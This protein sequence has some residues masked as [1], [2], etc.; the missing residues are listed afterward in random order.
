MTIPRPPLAEELQ[1]FAS[2]LW[3]SWN[4]AG[5][6]VFRQLDY[7]LWCQTDH[8]PIKI[9]KALPPERFEEAARDAGFRGCFERAVEQLNRARSGTATWWRERFPSSSGISI[10]YFSAEFGVHQ[11]V[12]LYA[13]GLGVLA[14][15]HCKE[16]SD[17]GVPL[18]GIGFRYSM[19]YFHQIITPEGNQI[20]IYDRFS[21]SDT[22]LERALRPD[23]TPC[24]V[25]I[26][27]AGGPLSI[28]VWLVRLGRV[29]VYLLDT[30]IEHNA[31]WARDLTAR[32]YVGELES[33][34]QQEVVLGLGGVRALRA[35]GYHPA[36]W[37]LNEGHAAFVILER[38][39][40]L[41]EAGHSLEQATETVRS[42]TVFTTHT[43]VP[44]GH[45]SFPIE[46]IEDQFVDFENLDAESRQALFSLG[47]HDNG[48]GHRFNMTVLA[49]R[50]SASC[51]AVSQAH[52]DVTRSMFAT[53]LNGRDDAV[54]GITNGVH[55]G[56]W[57]APAIDA[58]FQRYLGVNW[59]EHQDDPLFWEDVSTIPDEELWQ[60]RQ[61]LK[62]YLLEII[63]EHA[64][65]RWTAQKAGA[66]QLAASGTLLDPNALTIGFSRRFT[67]YKR[68][69]LIFHDEERLARL[70]SARRNPVQLIF[71]GKAHPADEAGKR[72]LQRIY[73]RAADRRF[74]G[75]IA[76]IDEY[77]L[78]IA[79]FLV[80]GCDV[81]L[82]NPR[83]PLEACGTSG[84]KASINGVPHLSVADGWWSE[85]YNG[86]NGWLI[87][88]DESADDA[89][90]AE[91]I[92]RLLEEHIVP[93]FYERD[94]R[95]VPLR[96]MSIVKQ[97]IRTVAPRF[98]ARRMVKQYVED[99]YV[100]R[101][102]GVRSASAGSY[103]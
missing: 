76:F 14:G 52:R 86:A 21:I 51:N 1:Q 77:N 80:Q 43:P 39:R 13:G 66:S 61:S 50:G 74:A 64:R 40:E 88:S 59:R 62:A 68:P 63:R 12:P 11:S 95:G 78:H 90:E 55:I 5:R 71:A 72:S 81:W 41:L 100:P 7:A 73:T 46:W 47:D 42:T 85:G 84:M 37:H 34:L 99:M 24:T 98:C 17:L 83:K 3:W 82:N 69:E 70:L 97:A 32:L 56:T 44:A 60:V 6:E 31:G 102:P 19:G 33:R 29:K 22:P 94:G 92:Y 4:P 96:W 28:D 48:S 53:I 38:I 10:A 103:D 27:L 36:V 54:L 18:I 93:A 49:L 35:L 101:A 45:D 20:E 8:N 75:R 2:D 67:D 15:D 9:L 65:N 79:Q 16:A 87:H 91:A 30:D 57:I 58:L 26:S 23:G 25:T 89:T